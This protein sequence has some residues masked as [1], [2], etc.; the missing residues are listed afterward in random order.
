MDLFSKLVEFFRSASSWSVAKRIL[1]I[2]AVLAAMCFALFGSTA[3]TSHRSMSVSVDK[4]EKVNIN[5]TDSING[6]IPFI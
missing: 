1:L 5:L 6:Q 2:I 3:C 4:A